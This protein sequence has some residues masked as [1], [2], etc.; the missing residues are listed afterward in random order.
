MYCPKNFYVSE[1]TKAIKNGTFQQNVA[2]DIVKRMLRSIENFYVTTGMT[3]Y[4]YA[5]KGLIS[6]IYDKYDYFDKEKKFLKIV[7]Q[8][9][10][11][12]GVL[13]SSFGR[14]EDYKKFFEKCWAKL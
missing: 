14:M 4:S 10:I 11:K 1:A 8:E 6:F 5:N 7:K 2:G 9:A 12:H 3:V 13:S